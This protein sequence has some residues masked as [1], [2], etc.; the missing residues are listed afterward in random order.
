MNWIIRLPRLPIGEI[1]I[2]FARTS[3][4]PPAAC[5]AQH[6]HSLK[7]HSIAATIKP[8]RDYRAITPGKFLPMK[9]AIC[10]IVR[11]EA[12]DIAEWIAFHVMIGFDTQ[13][14][15]DNQSTDE[16]AA[17]IKAAAGLHDIRYHFWPNA[18]Q[19]SQ[20][21]AYEA[22]CQA[23]KLEFDWIAFI[24]SDEF[25]IPTD[26]IPINQFLARFEGFSGVALHWAIFGANGHVDFPQGGVLESFTRRAEVDFFPARHVKCIIRPAF[27]GSCLNPHCFELRGDRFGSY[28]DANGQKM[29]WWPAPEAGGLIPGLSHDGPD[30]TFCRI[31]HYFTRS[32]AHWLAKLKR[33]YPSDVAVRKMEEFETYDRNEVE[34]TL[35]LRYQA[36]LHAGIEDI[37]GI[38]S[39][40]VRR[41][42]RV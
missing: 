19:K 27:A 14:I 9:S 22:A 8:F 39:P 35:A 31:N 29:H 18:S 32:R 12:R 28:C 37:L 7:I 23:Y 6:H 4:I 26:D 41:M 21:L 36:R 13:I 34:D 10:L 42:R 30:Y 38:A 20:V 17:I 1:L 3:A 15:F 5:L 40:T 11:N 2:T 16:T 24:D 33:G 25:I